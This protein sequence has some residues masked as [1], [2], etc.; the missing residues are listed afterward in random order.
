MNRFFDAVPVQT[1]LYP[2]F[3]GL[4]VDFDHQAT[5][6]AGSQHRTQPL[7]G[8]TACDPLARFVTVPAWSVFLLRAC[9]FS[10][11]SFSFCDRFAALFGSS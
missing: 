3:M 8:P 2:D 10:A 9:A 11:S 5:A 1:R 7:F 6:F 4:L